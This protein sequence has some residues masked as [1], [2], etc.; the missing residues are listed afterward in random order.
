MIYTIEGLDTISERDCFIGY[1]LTLEECIN[2]I[3]ECK[4]CY[5]IYDIM[6]IKERKPGISEGTEPFWV[7]KWNP[8][9]GQYCTKEDELWR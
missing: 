8:D 2:A 5:K 3:A 9:K 1:F 4:T 6:F 7:Y